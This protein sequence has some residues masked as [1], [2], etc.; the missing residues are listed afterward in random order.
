[1]KTKF[2]VHFTR[3]YTRGKLKGL[4]PKS[5]LV[6]PTLDSAKTWI[7]HVESNC[8]L[9]Y[10]PKDARVTEISVKSMPLGLSDVR[11]WNLDSD[12]RPGTTTPQ[13]KRE[14]EV[15]PGRSFTK[16]TEDTHEAR[17]FQRK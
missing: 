10:V 16:F 8:R 13:G 11:H 9:D 12:S 14:L 2:C 1:M 7:R 17:W 3:Q 15:R 6:F 5:S 4:T